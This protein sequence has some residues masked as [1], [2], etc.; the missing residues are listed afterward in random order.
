[1]TLISPT[2]ALVHLLY[3]AVGYRLLAKQSLRNAAFLS[4]LLFAFNL[5]A[6]IHLGGGFGSPYYGFWLGLVVMAG[7]LGSYVLIGSAFMISLYYIMTCAP[8]LTNGRGVDN[9][10]LLA[11]LSWLAAIASY[12]IWRGQWA[13]A[14]ETSY[15]KELSGA[16]SEEQLKS[17]ILLQSIGDGVIIVNLDGNIQFLNRAAARITGWEANDAWGLDYRLVLPLYDEED[18]ELTEQ[19][20]P[21]VAAFRTRQS[22]I[23]NDVILRAKSQGKKNLSI[24]VSPVVNESGTVTGGIAVFRD[25]SE[26]KRL[27]RE[28]NEFI[29][30]ASH[31]MRTPIAALE[32]FLSLALNPKV[33]QLDDSARQYVEKAYGETQH[34]GTL[35]RDLLS[36]S[37]LEEEGIASNPQPV[38]MN[39]IIQIAVEEQRFTADKKNLKLK[40]ELSGHAAGE[41][42]IKPLYYVYGDPDRLREVLANL[43]DNAIK[44]TRQG[45]IKITLTGD[46]NFVTVGVHDTGA[47]IDPA[48]QQHL[49][50][51]FYRIDN[52]ATRTVG[53]TGLGLYIS[54]TI[55]EASNGRIWVESRPGEGSHFYFSLPRLSYERATELGQGQP[56]Q[57]APSSRFAGMSTPTSPAALAAAEVASEAG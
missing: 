27:E 31:E 22:D 37:R 35:F 26:D 52:S 12:F 49:F 11:G 1:M 3:A 36:V 55:I 20:D 13:D 45:E 23:R 50:Q 25:I 43:I 6:T 24:S 8:Q 2:A 14:S 47:G 9:C 7:L 40:F 19:A 18:Q 39:Q 57:P 46:N 42:S 28:R 16:L 30:T 10:E 48:D 41:K 29:S 17:Q 53:G 15:V 33:S 38:E 44:F 56:N 5:V 51:K 21:F 34:L 32:G 4:L 54:R